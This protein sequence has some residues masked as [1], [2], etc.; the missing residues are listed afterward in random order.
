MRETKNVKIPKNSYSS[1]TSWNVLEFES[2]KEFYDYVCNTPINE[3]FR[4]TQLN[5]S[6]INRR[7]WYGTDTFEEATELLKNGWDV[8]AE[9]LT[10]ELKLAE[11]QKDVQMVYKNILS[12]CGFQAIVPL[13]LQGVPNNMVN[14]RITPIK[15]KV[16]TINKVISV[17]SSIGINEGSEKIMKKVKGK[18]T[19][20]RQT[21]SYKT[22]RNNLICIEIEDEEYRAIANVYLTP[23]KF[24]L[25]LTALACQEC[26][27]EAYVDID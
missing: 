17:S 10:R 23:E 8:A 26:E 6:S 12:V 27:I 24:S 11:T 21:N 5:S 22:E 19:I 13:Y 25:A 1:E 14:K 4:W 7:G 9:D 20:S 18:I 2:I 3:T 15:N 16:I